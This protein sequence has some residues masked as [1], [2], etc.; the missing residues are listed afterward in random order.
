MR[1]GQLTDERRHGDADGLAD[2]A[3]AAGGLDAQHEPLGSLIDGDLLDPVEIADDVGPSGPAPA[4]L[5]RSPR[6]LRSMS[7]R[8]EQNGWPTMAASLW[9]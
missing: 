5:S 6:S 2:D 1:R 7:A 8:K 3:G 9:W 4:G